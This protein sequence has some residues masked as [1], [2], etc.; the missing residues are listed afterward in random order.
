MRVEFLRE[1]KKGSGQ[2]YQSVLLLAKNFS[3]EFREKSNGKNLIGKIVYHKKV[4]V[5]K[6]D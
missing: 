2:I 4:L 6:S 5:G 1:D 3:G